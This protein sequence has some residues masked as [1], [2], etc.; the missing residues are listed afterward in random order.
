QPIKPIDLSVTGESTTVDVPSGSTVTI[1]AVCS[2]PLKTP[3]AS[4]IIL[5]AEGTSAI[6]AQSALFGKIDTDRD[7]K[8]TAKEFDAFFA[9]R[10]KKLNKKNWDEHIAEL[11]KLLMPKDG[12]LA[13]KDF[14]TFFREKAA[15][16]EGKSAEFL[17]VS[18]Q[19]LPEGPDGEL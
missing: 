17:E 12:A 3:D 2:K 9:R 15:R 14:F 16:M 11:K 5:V 18:Q 8:A 6:Q 19:L 13:E 7:G 4:S 10:M 1:R